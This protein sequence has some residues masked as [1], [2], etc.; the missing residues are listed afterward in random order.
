MNRL[1]HAEIKEACT[2]SSLSELQA[3]QLLY[4]IERLQEQAEHVLDDDLVV[5]EDTVFCEIPEDRVN[6]I[7][8]RLHFRFQKA[9]LLEPLS[10]AYGRI[11]RGWCYQLHGSPWRGGFYS[12]EAAREHA[13]FNHV[14]MR[15][16]L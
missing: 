3:R 12:I 11:C 14:I 1:A 8:R 2:K 13:F 16:G 9:S 6:E 5:F 4:K 7:L 15:L 10:G